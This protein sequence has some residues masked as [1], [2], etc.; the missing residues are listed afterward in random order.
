MK[1]G[2]FEITAS[3][4]KVGYSQIDSQTLLATK[5]KRSIGAT[6]GFELGSRP[7]DRRLKDEKAIWR[8]LFG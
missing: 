8:R 1:L 4:Q 2:N 3:Y 6:W 5:W 7:Q